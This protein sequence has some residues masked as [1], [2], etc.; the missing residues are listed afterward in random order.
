MD[1]MNSARIVLAGGCFWGT[2]HLFRNL[3]GVLKTQVGYVNSEVVNPTYKEVCTGQTGAA[4][5][6]E[7]TYN[8]T[9]VDLT[10]LLKLYFES[11]DPTSINR[12]GND[13]GTQY[14]TGIYYTSDSQRTT[15][16]KVVGE[17]LKKGY[18]RIVVEVLPLK[19]FYPAEQ[20]H[21]D[22]LVKNPEG[23][24]HVAPALL[25]KARHISI[26]K[27]GVKTKAEDAD[28]DFL[29]ALDENG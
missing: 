16:L 11:I 10:K 26:L 2:Q 29:H 27:E 20:E 24:C 22:Y 23:Y 6:V 12:Q 13:H 28:T 14:R 8:A 15:A 1:T 9:T 7:I 18:P 19:N 4:E 5:G 25:E 3:R 17:E 21:Q